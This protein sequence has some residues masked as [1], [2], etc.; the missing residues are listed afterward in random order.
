[1]KLGEKLVKKFK[2]W[3]H[4]FTNFHTGSR[5]LLRKLTVDKK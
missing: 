1:M 5:V 3:N 2:K 4:L